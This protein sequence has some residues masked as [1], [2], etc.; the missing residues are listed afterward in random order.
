M[1]KHIREEDKPFSIIEDVLE[2]DFI[3]DRD[4]ELIVGVR[5]KL[6]AGHGCP[7]CGHGTGITH[8]QGPHYKLICGDCGH[9]IKFVPK[10]ARLREALDEGEDDGADGLK[11]NGAS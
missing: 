10:E 8:P 11:R 3:I 6:F 5:V 4:G 2:K 7:R 1:S 9:Y